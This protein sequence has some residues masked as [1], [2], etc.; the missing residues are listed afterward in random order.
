MPNTVFLFPN[1]TGHLNPTLQIAKE[2]SES[3]NKVYYASTMDMMPFA[4]KHGYEFYALN[5]LPFAMGMEDA[6]HDT[7]KEKWLESLLDRYSDKSYRQRKADISRLVKEL[8]PEVIFLDEF[9]YSDF[10]LLYPFMEGRRIVLL[11]TKFPMYFNEK[12][13]PLNSYA[14][15]GD[16]VK[17]LWQRYFIKRN[18]KVLW[19]NIKYL[20][21]SDLSILKQKFKE[22]GVSQKYEINT[23]KVFRP[24][25]NNLEEWFL[26][27]K[28]LD[29]QEQK[30]LPWQK[31]VEP[32]F[33]LKRKEEI[34]ESCKKFVEHAKSN[35]QNK[36]IYCSLGTVLKTHAKGKE[37]QVLK[38]FQNL[39]ALAEE[40]LNWYFYAVVEKEFLNELKPQSPNIKLLEYAPQIYLL[41]NADLFITHAGMG[42]VNEAFCINV[43]M[44]VVPLNNKWDQNGTAA[45]V[46]YKGLGQKADLKDSKEVLRK[47]ISSFF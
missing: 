15:P 28:E 36:L 17:W 11:Q 14:F 9:N 6:L 37:K 43:P 44:L 4:K 20:G 38:F 16:N 46:V 47:N 40:N 1:L 39:I 22:N 13:P 35:T 8:D 3:G 25:F 34:T 23:Q 27:K 19:S 5:S 18:L 30:L 24:T 29:F 7:K 12:V 10:I 42:S 31:Y 21:K 26:V 45:R 41:N 33:D 32:L 2:Q